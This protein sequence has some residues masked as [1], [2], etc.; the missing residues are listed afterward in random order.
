MI[1]KLAKVFGLGDK[2]QFRAFK[3][4]ND[5]CTYNFT[6]VN[7]R[8]NKVK[9]F[10]KEA[11]VEADFNIHALDQSFL[12]LRWPVDGIRTGIPERDK[13]L[14]EAVHFFNG[15]EYPEIVFK[16]REISKEAKNQLIVTGDLF[17]K[18]HRKTV[19]LYMGYSQDKFGYQLFVDYSLDRFEFG[20]GESGSF[21]IGRQIELEFDICLQFESA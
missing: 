5:A 2:E 17:I 8:F 1:S 16:S 12:N 18:E 20:I 7:M 19:A 4:R 13:Q 10:F 6:A 14:I 15:L 9:G 3:V 11:K 21:A